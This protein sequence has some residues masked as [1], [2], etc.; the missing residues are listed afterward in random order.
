MS[1][2]QGFPEGPSPRYGP[3]VP[4]PPLIVCLRNSE[5]EEGARNLGNKPGKRDALSLTPAGF[6]SDLVGKWSHAAGVF[7]KASRR[8]MSVPPVA[9][10]GAESDPVGLLVNGRECGVDPC[11]AGL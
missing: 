11:L 8:L 6:P 9:G 5:V 7:W 1:E 4:P 2:Y 3:L 10:L